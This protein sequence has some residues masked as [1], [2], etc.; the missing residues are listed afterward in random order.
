MTWLAIGAVAASF[1]VAIFYVAYSW[2]KQQDT[3]RRHMDEIA[4]H[5]RD[6][7]DRMRSQMEQHYG[8]HGPRYSEIRYPQELRPPTGGPNTAP[9]GHIEITEKG[10]PTREF[11]QPPAERVRR[12]IRMED[13]DAAD[14]GSDSSR[15]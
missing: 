13:D 3:L 15:D 11:L 7:V 8:E 9:A 1:L 12:M 5:Q 6:D 10:S 2:Q 4:R 14:T